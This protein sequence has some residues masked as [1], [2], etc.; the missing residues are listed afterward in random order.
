MIIESIAQLELPHMD[1]CPRCS[2]S[3]RMTQIINAKCP[4]CFGAGKISEANLKLYRAMTNAMLY[5]K[6]DR[7]TTLQAKLNL[8]SLYGRFAR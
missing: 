4:W 6:A 7:T 1:H 3:G 5:N 8:S 2:G